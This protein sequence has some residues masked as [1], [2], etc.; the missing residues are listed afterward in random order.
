MEDFEHWYFLNVNTAFEDIC[1]QNFGG[2]PEWRTRYFW[3]PY[4]GWKFSSARK[5]VW[6]TKYIEWEKGQR[7]TLELLLTEQEDGS[8]RV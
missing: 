7:G 2:L 1:I 4:M 6:A 8:G 3:D 5:C